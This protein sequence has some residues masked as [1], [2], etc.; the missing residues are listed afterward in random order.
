MSQEDNMF[1][2]R[3]IRRCLAAGV[4]I[5]AASLPSVAMGTTAHTNAQEQRAAAVITASTADAMQAAVTAH[6][7]ANSVL[8][9]PYIEQKVTT[10][11][12]V[13]LNST[14]IPAGGF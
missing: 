2:Q 4:M 6:G 5:A 11:E 10:A 8:S 1:N 14:K 3:A 7:Q 13:G 12:S 9:N